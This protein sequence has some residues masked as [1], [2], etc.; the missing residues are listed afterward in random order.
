MESSLECCLKILQKVI[1]M[2]AAIINAG[3]L[4]ANINLCL[5]RVVIELCFKHAFLKVQ[6]YY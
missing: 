5:L 4:I 1:I 2:H 3:A 6:F